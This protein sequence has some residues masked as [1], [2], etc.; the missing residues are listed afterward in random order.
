MQTLNTE[1]L[2]TVQ[3]NNSANLRARIELHGRFST[4]PADWFRWVFDH[5]QPGPQAEILELGSGSGRL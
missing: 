5:F 3:Y 1:Y 2:R 4:N